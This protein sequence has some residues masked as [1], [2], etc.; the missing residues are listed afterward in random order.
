MLQVE[1]FNRSE[2]SLG[3]IA[4]KG[5]KFEIALNEADHLRQLSKDEI[6]NSCIFTESSKIQMEATKTS[7]LKTKNTYKQTMEKLPISR[8]F[9]K[10]KITSTKLPEQVPDE[11]NMEKVFAIL[12]P[13]VTYNQLLK[14][15]WNKK[16]LGTHKTISVAGNRRE[17]MTHNQSM[18]TSRPIQNS[19]TETIQQKHQINTRKN[20]G[21]LEIVQSKRHPKVPTFEKTDRIQNRSCILTD[22]QKSNTLSKRVQ[23]SAVDDILTAEEEAQ[24]ELQMIENMLGIVEDSGSNGEDKQR[25]HR[26]NHYPIEMCNKEVCSDQSMAELHQTLA[27]DISETASSEGGK[28]EVAEDTWICSLMNSIDTLDSKH[29]TQFCNN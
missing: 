5:K 18:V 25:R 24:K 6:L 29:I 17:S 23:E 9:Q 3:S 14:S 22:E 15:T 13:N 21:K 27:R 20:L 19:K 7:I 28:M 2:C 11:L 12:F 16:D 26:G 4:T 1:P 8:K 10:Q